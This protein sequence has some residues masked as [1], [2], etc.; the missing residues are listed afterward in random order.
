MRSKYLASACLAAAIALGGSS[1]LRADVYGLD[2]VPASVFHHGVW[3][4]YGSDPVPTS[5]THDFGLR[6]TYGWDPVPDFV[7]P[8]IDHHQRVLSIEAVQM[9]T[10]VRQVEPA[11]RRVVPR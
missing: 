8:H 1:A 7:H 2:V 10:G 5:T 3:N 11:V 9:L 4:F 6:T